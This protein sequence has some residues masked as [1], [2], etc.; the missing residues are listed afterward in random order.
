[1]PGSREPRY[2]SATYGIRYMKVTVWE[3]TASCR[4]NTWPFR[5]ASAVAKSPI[6]SIEDRATRCTVIASSS[7][8][9]ASSFRSTS[10]RIGSTEGGAL[11]AVPGS[12]V[13]VVE[14]PRVQL[15]D[16]VCVAVAQV[17]EQ[18]L[19]PLPRVGPAAVRMRIV[20]LDHHLVDSD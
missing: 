20:G 11:T 12:I 14:V 2:F 16:A 8:T 19:D 5:S 3:T 18:A 15:G 1:S 7:V 4:A 13:E 9:A 17:C 10:S 6:R